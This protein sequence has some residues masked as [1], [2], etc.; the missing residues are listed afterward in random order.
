MKALFIKTPIPMLKDD[1]L[2]PDMGLLYVATYVQKHVDMNVKC[3]DLSVDSLQKLF[4]ESDGADIFCFS[5]FTANYYLTVE[6]KN[7][8][9]EYKRGK[10]IYIAGGHHVSALP[11]EVKKDFDYVITGE[12]EIV[13]KELFQAILEGRELPNKII[14]G[15]IIQDLNVIDDI[16]Y[17]LVDIDKYTRIVNGKKALSILTSRGCPYKCEFCNSTLS[18]DGRH[19]RYKS[20]QKV[21][22]EIMAL[23]K[24][25][26]INAFRIQ[27]DIFSINRRRLNEMADLL[28]DYH[29]DFRCFAR[30]DNIDDEIIENFKRIGVRHI[31]FGI[32]SGSQ[33]ILNLM[34]KGL[35]VEIVKK[36]LVKIMEEG[37]MVRIFLIVGYPGETYETLQET[38]NLVKECHPHEV[39]VYPLIPYPGTPLYNTPQK[40]DITYIDPDFSKY[41]QI[42]G[43]KQ[44]GYV[45]ETSQLSIDTIKEM[46]EYLM[47]SIKDCC[48]WAIDSEENV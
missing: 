46:R 45:F 30:I 3:V 9:K 31:S 17:D 24:K 48:T 4:E 33:K 6:L 29:F 14:E 10:G 13:M 12:G 1:A 18:K 23:N 11:K 8:I 27:D 7:K 44:S 32:E 5:T 39:S 41:Y 36:N 28:E 42:Y 15:K 26:G 19:V 22:N 35:N 38:I 20:A 37:F 21:F 43:D 16:N 25:Y 34:N 2:E 47:D 40:Y